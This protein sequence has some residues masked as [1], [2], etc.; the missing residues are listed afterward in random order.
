MNEKP[1]R[2]GAYVLYWMQQS[3]REAFNPALEFA[4]KCAREAAAPLVV[5]FGL[6]PTYPEANARHYQFMLEGLQETQRAIERRGISFVLRWGA[7][8]D[9]AVRL[10][11]RAAHVICD[12][13]Y[14]RHQRAWRARVAAE[15]QCR[16]TQV[17]GDAV[18]PV[19]LASDKREVAAY[20]LRPKILR[21][22]DTFMV[23]L[24]RESDGETRGGQSRA[25]D[26]LDLGSDV[27]LS[28]LAS[29][30][31]A[32]PIDQ[33]V[34][35]VARFRGGTGEAHRRLRIFAGSGT[36]TYQDKRSEPGHQAVSFLSPYLHFGQ[37]SPVEVALEVRKVGGR[38]V[39]A[40]LDELIVRR[41]L[42]INYVTFEPE[43]DRYDA[44]PPWARATLEKHRSDPR[45]HRYDLETLEH[46]RTDDRYWNAAMREMVGTGYMHNRMRMYWG[47][48]ILEWSSDPQAAFATALRLNNKYFLCGRDANA[49]ANVGWLFGLHDR[50]WPERP[51]FGTVRS[52]TASGLTRKAD[53]EAYVSLVDRLLAA[54]P[55]AAAAGMTDLFGHI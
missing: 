6:S 17:E 48:K 5:G 2:T 19:D 51:V 55:S 28:D 11:R 34:A 8:D 15:A 45:P 20:T 30:V 10:A 39:A 18:V 16:V 43:Y 32:L 29:V 53:M 13:G 47:K 41:E 24:A 1:V 26:E 3:Q 12:R 36:D 23:P 46:A 44:L 49:Y 54:E 50:P 25:R 27:D 7:P 22:H 35:P 38:G 31:R 52:M 21:H 4:V 14:L 9:V 37:I 33:T 42:A 40:Y